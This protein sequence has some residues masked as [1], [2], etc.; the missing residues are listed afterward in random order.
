MTTSSPGAGGGAQRPPFDP[1]HAS[2]AGQA[3]PPFDPVVPSSRR[4][5]LWVIGVAAVL[6]AGLGVVAVLAL[7][8]RGGVVVVPEAEVITLPVPAPTVEPVVREPGTAFAEALPS[9]VLQYALAEIAD[10]PT[11]VAAGALEGYRFV[12]T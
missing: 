3:A 9:A 7:S 8:N 6:L 4:P 1:V 12:Y 2:G 11:L 5:P 10:E